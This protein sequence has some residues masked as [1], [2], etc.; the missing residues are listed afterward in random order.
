MAN[1][2]LCHRSTSIM[3][4]CYG[5]YVFVYSG[6]LRPKM[7]PSTLESESFVVCMGLCGHSVN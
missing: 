1:S 4:C 3:Y 6:G 2:V 5:A 7:S